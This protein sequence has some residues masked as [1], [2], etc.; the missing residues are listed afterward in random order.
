MFHR[1]VFNFICLS[2]ILI[3]AIVTDPVKKMGTLQ[4]MFL[5]ILFLALAARPYRNVHSNVIFI[6]LSILFS[7]ITFELNMKVSG[8]K[9]TLF[10]DKY[11]YAMQMIQNAFFW[12]MIG[13]YTYL[14]Y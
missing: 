5:I 12:V 1:P 7:L 14:I 9:S 3:H 6:A 10:V 2:M 11:F 13:V 8:F 4:L